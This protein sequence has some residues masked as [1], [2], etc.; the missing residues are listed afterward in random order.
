[1]K[2][3]TIGWGMVFL[4]LLSACD[5]NSTVNNS[6]KPVINAQEQPTKGQILP[7]TAQAT[8]ARQTINLEVA[9][10]STQQ[11]TGL[12]FREYLQPDRGMLFPFETPRIARFW[13]KNVSIPLDMVFLKG[14]R[15]VDIAINVPPCKTESC[16]VYGPDVLVDRVLELSGG[17][18]QEL[19][20]KPGDKITIE[21][22][23]PSQP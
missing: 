15:V 21:F 19:G 1:M 13:M 2:K 14:D 10:T 18:S 4:I 23:S 20:L 8:I 12:M 22:I 9:Q 17:R 6:W 11:A 7:I 3:L 16:P 5:I